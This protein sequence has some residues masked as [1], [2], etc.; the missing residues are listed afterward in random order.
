M[1]HTENLEGSM[2]G[3]NVNGSK[4]NIAGATT[5][6]QIPELVKQLFASSSSLE[7]YDFGKKVADIVKE[8]GEFIIIDFATVAYLCTLSLPNTGIL[9]LKQES[10]LDIYLSACLNKKSGFE[11]EGGALGFAGLAIVLGNQSLP[12]LLPY[13]QPLLDLESDKGVPVR[14][15][16]HLAIQNILDLVDEFSVGA[17]LDSLLT[18]TS[19]KWQTKLATL[20][21]LAE[22]AKKFPFAIADCLPELIPAVTNCMHD[23]KQE[24]SKGAIDC[25]TYLCKVVAN[26]DIDPHINLLIDCMAHP[27]HVVKTVQTLSATT[28]VAEVTGPALA[29]MVP[30]L[31]RALND[32]SASVMRPTT[33]IA[34]NL[35]KLVRN[36]PDAGQF[37]PQLL[38]GLDRIIETAAFPEIRSLAQTAR[39]TL[40]KAAGGE[41]AVAFTVSLDEIKA[42]I[43]KYC[44][45]NRV[46]L[47]EFFRPSVEFAARVINVLIKKEN[48]KVKVTPSP[49]LFSKYFILM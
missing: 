12:L 22:F 36:P 37:L 41:S 2:E 1:P 33:V 32:R 7:C 28:F 20:D 25:M 49:S 31:V 8:K 6:A 38:P 48:F 14:E 45:N 17:T 40:V 16:A 44:K 4:A 5:S 34:D 43:E 30:L 24:V 27:D 19:G 10:L 15:A 39:Q 46:F 3:L 26:P 35:F 9:L 29:L 23:T 42:E 11:R 18:G 47:T 13:L 21:F